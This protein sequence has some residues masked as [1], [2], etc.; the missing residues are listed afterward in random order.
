[1]ETAK[2]FFKQKLTNWVNLYSDDLFTWAIIKVKNDTVAKD[3]VQETFIDAYNSI[4]KF[5]EK[6]SPKT[7]LISILKNKIR[8]Y[9]RYELK[10]KTVSLTEYDY[11]IF[12]DK[13]RWN[14][15]QYQ[16]WQNEIELL[17]D[18]NFKEIFTNCIKNL[19]ELWQL[20]VQ[21]KYIDGNKSEEICNDLEL[22]NSN[23]WQIIHRSKL[24]LRHCLNMNWFKNN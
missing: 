15:K 2:I 7:W 16:S 4:D 22:S 11:L 12:N 19:P 1:M 8:M 6:S 23:Y 17:D 10:N 20:V 21:S 24:K 14:Q 3:L 13:G 18:L 9:F 5:E